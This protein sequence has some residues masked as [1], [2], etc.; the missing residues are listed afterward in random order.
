MK[1][2]LK[3]MATLGTV[4]FRSVHTPKYLVLSGDTLHLFDTDTDGDRHPPDL[5]AL[6]PKGITPY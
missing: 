3:G 4:R 5:P 6:T 1:N 2:K